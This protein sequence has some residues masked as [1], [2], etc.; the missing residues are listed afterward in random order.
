MV[1]MVKKQGAHMIL[2]VDYRASTVEWCPAWCQESNYGELWVDL[3][4]LQRCI[5]IRNPWTCW[6]CSEDQPYGPDWSYS[7]QEE[8]ARR[9]DPLFVGSADAD[10][11]HFV[12]VGQFKLSDLNVF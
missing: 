6:T 5:G 8:R 7:D 3:K 4:D 9:P 12:Q 1:A 11:R 10:V 2:P